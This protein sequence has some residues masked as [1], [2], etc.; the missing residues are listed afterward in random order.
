[1]GVRGLA[2]VSVSLGLPVVPSGLAVA[3]PGGVWG[4]GFGVRGRSG[5]GILLGRLVFKEW[6]FPLST[7][8]L[9]WDVWL[10]APHVG[11]KM[12]A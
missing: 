12:K 8:G 3:M 10:S 6:V 4:R 9:A 2:R 1:M 11:H 7:F 5:L